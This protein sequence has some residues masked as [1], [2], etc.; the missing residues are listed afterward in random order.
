MLGILK[1]I[2]SRPDQ[3]A[4]A[5]AP[6]P[7]P[8]RLATARPAYAPA[9]RPVTAAP[10]TSPFQPKAP[11]VTAA[12]V[13][14][15][16]NISLR[17]IEDSVPEALRHKI[18]GA[19]HELVPVPISLIVPQLQRGVVT[20]TVKQLR[21]CAPE[22]LAS[23]QGHDEIPVA[24]PLS[25]IV[26]QLPSSA[27]TRKEQQ[28]RVKVPEAV[29]AIFTQTETGEFTT[30]AQ[31]TPPPTPR[32]PAI[33]VTNTSAPSPAAMSAP[34][35]ASVTPAAVPAPAGSKISL[36]PEAMAAL[37]AAGARKPATAASSKSAPISQVIPAAAP[38]TPKLPAATALPRPAAP[39]PAAAPLV[40]A[41][42]APAADTSKLP[43]PLEKIADSLPAEVRREIT[44]VDVSATTMHLL[45]PQ[46]ESGLK[47]GKVLFTWN[48]MAASM[49]PP[50]PRPPSRSA[51]E[52]LVELP[53]RVMAPVFMAHHRAATSQKK[54]NV[55]ENIPDLF[56]SGSSPIA[57]PSLPMPTPAAAPAAEVK[58]PAPTK[59]PAAAPAER[60]TAPVAKPSVAPAPAAET[61]SL[62]SVVGPEGQR[63][64][65]KQIVQNVAKLS[66][67]TGAI[68]ALT[69]GLPV[70]S[71]V[72]AG[73]KVD[74]IAAFLPQMFGRMVQY[75]KD[76]ELGALHHLTLSVEGGCWVV[77][78]QQNIYF[79]AC[80]KSGET[81]PFNL[82]DQVAAELSKQTN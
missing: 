72:P 43:V 50:L 21:E 54:A 82:L 56:Q 47:S 22:L 55:G 20:V 12:P 74:T 58:I 3:A 46:V 2:W 71:A 45:M 73:V 69:D 24:L 35:A 79:A 57:A 15:F 52:L 32:V 10:A 16:V 75:T 39:K 38:A 8:P 26:K 65:P 63:F 48:D 64:A 40:M 66:G 59:A 34:V 31:P 37:A 62:E 27:Y 7:P 29:T 61:V 77:F 80:G 25:E 9:P 28:K 76:L 51:G 23:F 44:D 81:I 67:V 30:T 5:T 13:A 1:K 53:L 60:V 70:A 41:S 78:K 6:P 68:V 17:S 49:Q 4:V 33:R 42:A 36:S 11:P 14:G 18:A 19:L